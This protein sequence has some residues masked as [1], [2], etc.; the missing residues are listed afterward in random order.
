MTLYLQICISKYLHIYASVQVTARRPA[1]LP[2]AAH[3]PHRRG[4]A[5]AIHR[6]HQG[7]GWRLS[8]AAAGAGGRPQARLRDPA[9]QLRGGAVQT[10]GP[11]PSSHHA[12]A[13]AHRHSAGAPG[14]GLYFLPCWK[15]LLESI[16]TLKR[17]CA[18]HQSR[19]RP[20]CRP[21]PRRG[22]DQRGQGGGGGRGGGRPLRHPPPRH[23]G[24]YPE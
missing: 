21:R 15:R 16:K 24:E 19:G 18:G 9:P 3:S 1:Q 6:G 5:A 20:W 8:G 13:P 7:L 10:G 17:W 23:R 2:A 12:P 11:A 14:E 4:P 22:R